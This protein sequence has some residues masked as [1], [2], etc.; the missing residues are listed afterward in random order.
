MMNYI[1]DKTTVELTNR[2]DL[3]P[4]MMLYSYLVRQKKGEKKDVLERL[5]ENLYRFQVRNATFE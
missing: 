2:S 3:Y 4:G 1:K 5:K